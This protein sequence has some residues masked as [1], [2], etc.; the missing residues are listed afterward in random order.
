MGGQ[1]GHESH[2]AGAAVLSE[3]AEQ[4]RAAHAEHTETPVA[5]EGI[6]SPHEVMGHG[7]NAEM[8]MAAKVADM[9]NRFLVALPFSPI[10]IWPSIGEDVFGLDTPVPFGLR[11]DV[12]AMLLSLPV[13]FYS[14]FPRIPG[15]TVMR[16]RAPDEFDGI[17]RL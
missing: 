16:S 6:P 7:G 12:W 9:R 17:R 14:L 4:A 13:I 1:A 15:N 10:V 8:S 2:G 3:H 5:P 11:Q